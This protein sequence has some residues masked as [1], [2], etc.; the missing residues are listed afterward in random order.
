MII[1]AMAVPEVNVKC[2]DHTFEASTKTKATKRALKFLKACN[3]LASMTTSHNLL[4]LTFRK[5]ETKNS[6]IKKIKALNLDIEQHFVSFN[7]CNT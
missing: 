6:E 4:K 1:E 2:Q 7:L 5:M 3:G